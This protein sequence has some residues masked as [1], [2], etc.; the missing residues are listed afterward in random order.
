MP[1][2][3]FKLYLDELLVELLKVLLNV[4]SHF[5]AVHNWHVAIRDDDFVRKLENLWVFLFF[6][7]VVARELR[8][9]I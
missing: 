6:L 3:L 2:N 1:L 8:N 4:L 7:M 5:E 9:L